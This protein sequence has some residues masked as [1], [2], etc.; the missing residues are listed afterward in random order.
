M[1]I[2]C[3]IQKLS[4]CR[5]AFRTSVFISAFIS[6]KI[7]LLF[8]LKKLFDDEDCTYQPYMPNNHTLCVCMC[9]CVCVRVCTCAHAC[10]CVC[11]VCVCVRTHTRACVRT[12]VCICVCACARVH[13]HMCA[14]MCVCMCV[15]V[16]ELVM[17]KNVLWI[18][19][20]Y[21]RNL[22]WHS[23]HVY[24]YLFICLWLSNKLNIASVK[25]VFEGVVFTNFM[26]Q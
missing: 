2:A 23:T 4:S 17:F 19:V 7:P 13:A 22:L 1:Y 11:C 10:M 12:C 6:Q 25:Q 18:L 8:Q 26:N 3:K 16:C 15:C 20:T 24:S 21:I 9:V 5:W 14:C